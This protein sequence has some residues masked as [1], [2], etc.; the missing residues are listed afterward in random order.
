MVV[1][2]PAVTPKEAYIMVVKIDKDTC[3]GCGQCVD[4]CPVQALAMEDDGKVGV[5][6][7]LCVDCGA[8]V[9]VCPV[10]ALSM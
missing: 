9:G 5:D 3:I 10:T 4:T 7:D 6:A 8:C 2:T 1:A